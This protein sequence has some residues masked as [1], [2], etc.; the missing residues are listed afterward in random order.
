VKQPAIILDRVSKSYGEKPALR[1]VDLTVSPGEVLGLLGANGAGKTTL[2]DIL[3]GLRKP[4][5]G[6]GRILGHAL[7]GNRAALRARIGY[8]TQ[9]IVLPPLLTVREL[10]TL[11]ATF[12]ADPESPDALIEQLGLDGVSRQRAGQLSGG[13]RQRLALA[14]ALVGRPELLLLDEP[15]SA[16]DAHARAAVWQLLQVPTSR[17]RTIVLTTHRIDEAERFCDTVGILNDGELVALDHPARL[18]E[19]LGHDSGVDEIVAVRPTLESVFLELTS[20]SVSP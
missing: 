11:H 18:V 8:V 19:T 3:L 14:L 4:D 7:D 15:T 17:P 6:S 9:E 10:T 20:R 5:S 1:Q 13:E 16:L 12:H 2:I